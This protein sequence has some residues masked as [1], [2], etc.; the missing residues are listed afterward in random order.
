MRK[1]KVVGK[2]V[3]FYGAGATALTAA[4]R[5]TV[6]NM[7]PEYGATMGYFPVDEKTVD[8]FRTTGREPELVSAI[9]AYYKAQGMFGMPK[10]G[11]IDYTQVIELNL[12]TIVPSLSGPKRPQDR[13]SLP[14]LGRDFDKLFAVPTDKNGY[15]RQ[16]SDL[17]RR[18]ATGHAFD[19][20]HGDVLIASITSCTNTSNPAL[21]L[22][23]GLFAKRA[24]EKGLMPHPR[25]KT[26]LAPGSKVVTAYLRD[27][28]LLEPLAKLGFGVVAYGCTTCMGAAGPLDAKIEEAVVSKD[29][30]TCAVLSGNRN[31]E[32]RVHANL[33]ANYLASPAL[34]VAYALAGTVRTDLDKDPLG[35]DKDGKPV[36]L[37]DLWPTDAEVS[38]LLKFATNAD[39]FRR[40]YGDLSGNKKLW[41]AI[42]T[43]EGAVFKWD[44]KS[45]FIKEP[46]FFDGVTKTPGKVTDIVGA[47]ALAILGD[48]ITTD[49]ISPSTKDIQIT[50]PLI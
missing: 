35:K 8:Y 46:P 16:A 7:A 12:D 30:V 26:S 19:V 39:H 38:A 3:E 25:I 37:K 33:R 18:E 17:N 10:P 13:V 20:G 36:Y 27:A 6:A 47:R 22:A 34:V 31:F 43:I 49:H 9:E 50:Q 40:E 44:P 23:A 42:P 14:E 45:T 21:L 5:C 29:L 28:G 24:V 11:D 4:D 48:S 15:A 41:D 1:A 2:F 32:A